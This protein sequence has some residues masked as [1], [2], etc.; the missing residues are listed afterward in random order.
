MSEFINYVTMIA[1]PGKWDNLITSY[2]EQ[3]YTLSDGVDLSADGNLPVTH[4]G[5]F[6]KAREVNT[7]SVWKQAVDDSEVV[8]ELNIPWEEALAQEGLQVIKVEEPPK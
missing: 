1:S 4:K 2:A 6:T 7:V 5:T 8:I 3:G